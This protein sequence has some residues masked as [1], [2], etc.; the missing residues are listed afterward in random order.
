M[1]DGPYRVTGRSG[2]YGDTYQ[3]AGN[4]ILV[5]CASRMSAESYAG[6]LNAAHRAASEK[7]QRVVEAAR[8]VLAE[9]DAA[10]EVKYDEN[11]W[12]RLV[13]SGSHERIREALAD[14]DKG[15]SNE[16]S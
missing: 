7:A 1:S 8:R 14:Y 6:A 10:N 12:D 16:A 2:P 15:V 13:G 11:K 9:F 4:G 5:A 3:A